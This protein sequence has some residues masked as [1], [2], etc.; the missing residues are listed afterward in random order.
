MSAGATPGTT[1]AV[2]VAENVNVELRLEWSHAWLTISRSCVSNARHARDSGAPP[3]ESLEAE[4]QMGVLAIAAAAFA[5]EAVKLRVFGE[6][7]IQ[8]NPPRHP[9]PINFGDYLG[10]DLVA[11]QLISNTDAY[12]LGELFDLR[13]KSVHPTSVFEKPAPHPTGTSTSPEMVAYNVDVAEPLVDVAE[14]VI[15]AI[16]A[17]AP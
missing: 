3:H 4:F 16:R 12:S 11:R 14:R 9:W 8:S 10:A 1:G 17:I 5:V 15:E 13:H 7:K 6:P 2:A